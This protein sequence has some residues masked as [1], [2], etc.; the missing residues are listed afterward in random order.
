MFEAMFLKCS[1]PTIGE[2]NISDG[3]ATIQ[4]KCNEPDFE[5]SFLKPREVLSKVTV[6]KKNINRVTPPI[7]AY[8]NSYMYIRSYMYIISPTP[9]AKR[10]V[11]GK[12]EQLLS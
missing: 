5:T 3:I 6:A 8:A 1:Y 11:T 2:F 10:T 9:V 4:F 7:A 12:A